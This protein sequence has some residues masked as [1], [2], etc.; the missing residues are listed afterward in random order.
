MM[1][2]KFNFAEFAH[3]VEDTFAL[4]A[5]LDKSGLFQLVRFTTGIFVTTL[6]LVVQLLFLKKYNIIPYWTS[7]I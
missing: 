4:N 6:L 3:L 7:R 5:M 2:Y 1:Y